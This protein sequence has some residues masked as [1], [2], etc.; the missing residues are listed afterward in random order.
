MLTSLLHSKQRKV[1]A[2]LKGGCTTT[3][4]Q[5]FE[6]HHSDIYLDVLKRLDLRHEGQIHPRMMVGPFRRTTG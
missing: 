4:R 6:T 5:H 2:N 1:W 3:I